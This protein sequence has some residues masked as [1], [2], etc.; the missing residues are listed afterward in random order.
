MSDN[1]CETKTCR[2][3]SGF[4]KEIENLKISN[5]N[6]WLGYDKINTKLEK[7]AD[8]MP[9]WAALMFAAVSAIASSATT[10]AIF[11]K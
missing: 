2:E 10:Y 6:L 1:A 4:K 7:Y 3:H 11:V 8:R 5:V 9:N